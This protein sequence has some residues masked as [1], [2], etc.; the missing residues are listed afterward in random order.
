LFYCNFI[1]L[2]RTPTIKQK[3]VLF[4]FYFSF[5]AVVWSTLY[6]DFLYVFDEHCMFV[7]DCM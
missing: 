6:S 1:A 7:P 5:I 2:V 4:H 3:F